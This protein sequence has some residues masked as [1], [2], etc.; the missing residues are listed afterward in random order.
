MVL[1]PPGSQQLCRSKKR[2]LSLRYPHGWETV[3]ENE[4]DGGREI[5]AEAPKGQVEYANACLDAV[6]TTVRLAPGE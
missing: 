5:V 4:P 6:I 3:W 1:R 2:G